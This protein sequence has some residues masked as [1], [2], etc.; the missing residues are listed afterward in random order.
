MAWQISP[1]ADKRLKEL[2]SSF[3]IAHSQDSVI[4]EI[5]DNATGEGYFKHPSPAGTSESAAL[6]AAC[7]AVT[8]DK[9]PMSIGTKFNEQASAIA[10]KDAE[11]AALRAKLEKLG[12]K[13]DDEAP[14]AKKGKKGRQ[15]MID[16][17]PIS[18]NDE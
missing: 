9:R 6:D 18:D 16:G 12:G 4:I 5:I 15:I 7:I 3:R 17:E 14:V 1:A 8:D 2:R 11:I 13:I 10:A